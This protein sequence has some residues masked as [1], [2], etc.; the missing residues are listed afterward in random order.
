MSKDG[1]YG[2]IMLM[3][4]FFIG[5]VLLALISLEHNMYILAILAGILIGRVIELIEEGVKELKA[6]K[7]LNP[8]LPKP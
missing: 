3:Y 1:V 4:F 6:K 7:T 5:P 8:I 2:F